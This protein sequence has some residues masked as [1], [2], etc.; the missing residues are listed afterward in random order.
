MPSLVAVTGSV[1]QET[2]VSLDGD[3]LRAGPNPF[4][5]YVEPGTYDFVASSATSQTGGKVLVQRDVAVAGATTLPTIDT[6]QGV[7][8]M[9]KTIQI[10]NASQPPFVRTY[11]LV[12]GGVSFAEIAGR[13]DGMVD[14]LPAN[15]LASDD[16]EWIYVYA[17][18]AG[19]E[20]EYTGSIPAISLLPPLAGIAFDPSTPAPSASWTSLPTD[21]DYVAMFIQGEA[22]GGVIAI[23]ELHASRGWNEAH[24]A[25]SLSLASAIPGFKSTWGVSLGTLSELTTTVY[26]PQ[27]DGVT[28]W[29]EARPY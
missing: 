15:A 4:S 10:S 5:F 23:Q 25:T 13:S 12:D 14:V 19:A 16:E 9:A 29:T 27:R 24:A 3:T 22:F 8:L 18:G 21:Y 20:L 6:S 2:L 7:D 28:L 26:M 17:P 11:L 1:T